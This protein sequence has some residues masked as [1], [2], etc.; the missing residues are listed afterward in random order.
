MSKLKYILFTFILSMILTACGSGTNE[1]VLVSGIAS[2]DPLN[3]VWGFGYE[4]EEAT[5]PGPVITLTKGEEVTITFL[6]EALYEDGRTDTNRHN[7]M[8]VADKDANAS[9]MEVL[10]GAE[11]GGN[12]NY[13]LDIK[14]GES[15][16]VTFIPGEIGEFY[17]VCIS[18]GHFTHGMWGRLIVVESEG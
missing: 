15:A 17:Y 8:I 11:V 4:G 13:D 1:I 6:N 2:E 12:T 7:F 5:S 16:S 18:Q 10:W 14:T 9:A 3:F